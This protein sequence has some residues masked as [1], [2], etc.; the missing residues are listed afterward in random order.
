M[1]YAGGDVNRPVGF[2]EYAFASDVFSN[3]MITALW[4]RDELNEQEFKIVD[5]YINKMY[6]KFLQPKEFQKR[7]QGFYGMAN[8]G[9]S[10]LVYASWTNN[11]ETCCRRNKP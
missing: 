5:K 11:K 4:L 10:I 8:G 2:I 9:I 7:R 1:C 6:K 3:Y